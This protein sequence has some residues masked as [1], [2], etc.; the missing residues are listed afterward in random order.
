MPVKI[1][2]VDDDAE[3]REE[4]RAYLEEYE[5]IEAAS[6]DEALRILKRP[7]EIDLVILDVMMPGTNG[8]EVLREMKSIDPGLGIIILTGFSSKDVAVEALKGRADDYIEKSVDIGRIREVI[9]RLLDVRQP[10]RSPDLSGQK[11]KIARI[12]EFLERNCYKKVT[13]EDAARAVSL[14]PKY[15][16][17]IFRQYSGEGFVAYRQIIK[18]REG[19]RLLKAGDL[20]VDQIAEKLGYKNA[21]S[22][23]R[24]FKKLTGLTPSEFRGRRSRRAGRTKEDAQ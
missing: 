8:T 9:E 23:I 15:L 6:G 21:E 10:S 14:S 17:R 2:L 12:K 20:N 11:H 24:V 4:L 7:N 13:L 19:K 18:T 3:F 5:M 1:L 16:S 22:F